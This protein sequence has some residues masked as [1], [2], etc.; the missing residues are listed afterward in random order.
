MQSILKYTYMYKM[1]SNSTQVKYGYGINDMLC[2][3][4]D[5]SRG[6]AQYGKYQWLKR[7]KNLF[8]KLKYQN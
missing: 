2:V 1:D 3:Q 7:I 5:H 8:G 6:L 4:L